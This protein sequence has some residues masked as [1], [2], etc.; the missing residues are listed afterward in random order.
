MWTRA[1]R[2]WFAAGVASVASLIGLPAQAGDVV[3]LKDGKRLEGRV[4]YE[5]PGYVV[6]RVGTKDRELPL[7]TIAE[8]RSLART[9]RELVRRWQALGQ[10]DV[11]G[12]MALAAEARG[13][14]LPGEAE[15][16]AWSVL[17]VEPAH[18]P[19]HRFLGHEL[20]NQVWLVRDGSR[21]VPCEDFVARTRDFTD[22]WRFTTLHFALRTNLERRE[23]ELALLELELL[24]Q[25]FFDWFQQEL[26]LYEVVEPMRAELH[27]QQK[28][29]PGGSGR[30]GFYVPESNTLF[31][32]LSAGFAPDVLIHECTHALLH[33]TAELTP[34]ALGVLPAWV[35]EGLSDYMSFARQGPLGAPQ[36]AKATRGRW[37]FQ[38]HA[39]SPDPHSLARVLALNTADFAVSTHVGLSYA[40]SYTL[41]HYCLHGEEQALRPKFFEFLRRCYAGKASATDFK[42]ALEVK[43]APFEAAWTAYVRAQK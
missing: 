15:V 18:E 39:E 36:Y 27:A 40:Q 13:L 23:A 41:V 25:T 28:N 16:L 10:Q 29:Y 26:R 24:Y 6:L 11:A 12:R 43:A 34:R 30:L 32:N 38:L 31:A 5:G 37:Y 35:D 2:L 1:L 42:S 19:A 17:G 33:N 3:V 7:G 14:G 21:L 20:R 9:Q 8:L 4:L 22:A